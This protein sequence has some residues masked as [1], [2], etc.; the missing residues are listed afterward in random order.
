MK[1]VKEENIIDTL[2]MNHSVLRCFYYLME[3][4]NT[5]DIF[6][7]RDWFFWS[8]TITSR[9]SQIHRKEAEAKTLKSNR[10]LLISRP[11]T[12]FQGTFKVR[13]YLYQFCLGSGQVDILLEIILYITCY[14]WFYE[15]TK[16]RTDQACSQKYP[17]HSIPPYHLV[18]GAWFRSF[19]DMTHV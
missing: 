12:F 8:Q 15:L 11:P 14:F 9:G 3:V 18:L 5:W 17:Y 6:K 2:Y 16:L 13:T 4:M 7:I 10:Q 1:Y 19:T